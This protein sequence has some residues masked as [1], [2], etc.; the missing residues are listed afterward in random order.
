MTANSKRLKIAITGGIASG[1]STVSRFIRKL[2][3]NVFSADEIYT[4]LLEDERFCLE[5]SRILGIAPII[6]GKKATFDRRAAADVLFSDSDK[7]KAFDLFA[8]AAVY[9]RIDEIFFSQSAALTFF[10]IPLL[11]E[12]GRQADFDRVI[13]VIRDDKLRLESAVKRDGKGE[14][15]IKKVMAAQF[16]YNNPIDTKHT[17]LKND[18]D[19][20]ALEKKVKSIVEYLETT[21]G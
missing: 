19:M 21:T 8:H 2:G 15:Y 14:D 6:R 4:E 10:E 5:C 12:S 1:K 16:D 7:R 20:S 9:K 17:I 18:G 11:F 3:Y 13:V